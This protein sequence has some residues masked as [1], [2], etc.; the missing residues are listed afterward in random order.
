M[1]QTQNKNN[2][3]EAKCKCTEALVEE[4]SKSQIEKDK[5]YNELRQKLAEKLRLAQQEESQYLELAGQFE[6]ELGALR[7]ELETRTLQLNDV[8]KSAQEINSSRCMQ[9]ACAQ[10]E[11]NR[12]KEEL[13]KLLRKHC[14]LNCEVSSYLITHFGSNPLLRMIKLTYYKNM[15]I[16]EFLKTGVVPILCYIYFILFYKLIITI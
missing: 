8:K 15:T 5:E 12:L 2:E 4:M 10:E 9:L 7:Q 13:N 14:N 6:R 16:T 3:L 1:N 11:V